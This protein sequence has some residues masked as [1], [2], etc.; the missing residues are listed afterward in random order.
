MP[1]SDEELLARRRWSGRG[2]WIGVLVAVALTW[3][4]ILSGFDS[5]RGAFDDLRYHWP[6]VER[7]AEQLPTPDVSDYPSA[8]TPGYHLDLS[9]WR[10]LGAPRTLVRLYASLWTAILLGILGSMAHARLGRPGLALLAPVALSMYVLYPGIWLLPDNA[11]WVGVLVV[12]ILALDHPMSLRALFV[13]G[14]ALALL[15]AVRQIHI[16]AAA[17]VWCGAWIGSR[18]TTP[19]PKDLFTSIGARARW[20]ALALLAAAPAALVLIWFVRLWGGLVPP[21]FQGRHQGPNPITPGFILTQVAIL[22]AL[23]A[24]ILV[25]RLARI[26]RAQ[27]PWLV[28]ALVIGLAL[29]IAPE[30][31]YSTDAGRYSGWWN[32]VRELP[33]PMGRSIVLALGAP[34]G[35][36]CLVAWGSMLERRAAWILCVSLLAFTLA[37]SANHASW[38]RY[39]EPM[40]L[41]LGALT[42]VRAAPALPIGRVVFGSLALGCALG[43]ISAADLAGAKTVAPLPEDR[44]VADPAIDSARSPDQRGRNDWLASTAPRSTPMDPLSTPL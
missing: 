25:P 17:A 7:F 14:V 13:S 10:A 24:P 35:A 19:T 8:T 27:A 18:E 21:D 43:A 44:T 11:G 22:S 12:L 20:L 28:G 26:A 39:H 23:F 40:L 6:T 37:Q 42:I 41:I 32:I 16:W 36:V 33:A 3:P 29:G 5:G 38:Q 2:F 15:V 30:S 9:V 34:A 31:S 1:G 4:F